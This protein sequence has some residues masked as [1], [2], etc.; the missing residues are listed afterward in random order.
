M[1]VSLSVGYLDLYKGPRTLSFIGPGSPRA[2]EAF[3]NIRDFEHIDQEYTQRAL[4][5]ANY[6]DDALCFVGGTEGGFR[7][8]VKNRA[9][10]RLA[11]PKEQ[12]WDG[13]WSYQVDVTRLVT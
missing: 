10:A 7:Q 5:A 2:P 1:G 13:Q 6:Y 11:G 8:W 3:A 12:Y 9:K 4:L